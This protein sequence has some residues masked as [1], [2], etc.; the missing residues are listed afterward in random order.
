ME[1]PGHHVFFRG[2]VLLVS[3]ALL[4]PG[5]H[6]KNE[7]ENLPQDLKPEES[8]TYEIGHKHRIARW[9]NVN[10]TLFYIEYKD[11]F[12]VFYDSTQSYA[13]YKNTGDSEHVGIELEMDGMIT[14]YLGYRFAGNY[15]KAEWTSGRERVYTWETLTKQ[16]FRDLDGYQLNRVPE[17]TYMIGIDL[18]PMEHLRCN[19][20]FNVTGPFY[21]DYLNRIEYGERNTVDFGIRYERD[22]WSLWLLGKNIFDT[23]IES[24]YNSNGQL[25]S[26]AA[27]IQRNGAY[28]N[29]YY[30]KNGQYFEAGVTVRF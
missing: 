11:K 8:L 13:G 22:R 12:N 21:V 1:R 29:D 16:D 6:G 4:L 5:G 26:T 20:D 7:P 10:L 28:A 14:D 23:E 25:N 30:P 9:A 15:M 27:E 2:A 19:L 18:L 17:Y 3:G 24:V